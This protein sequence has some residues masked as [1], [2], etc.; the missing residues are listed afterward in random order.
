MER[1]NGLLTFIKDSLTNVAL[2]IKGDV[3]LSQDLEE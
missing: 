2:A 3:I 1:F